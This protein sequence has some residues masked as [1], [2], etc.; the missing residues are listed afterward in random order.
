MW[1]PKNWMN[2]LYNQPGREQEASA[3]RSAALVSSCQI[4][5]RTMFPRTAPCTIGIKRGRIFY[6]SR[7]MWIADLK[8]NR[9]LHGEHVALYCMNK[10]DRCGYP[11]VTTC[12]DGTLAIPECFEGKSTT[13]TKGSRLSS[14]G[15]LFSLSYCLSSLLT[16]FQNQGRWDTI[17][18]P[19]P[20]HQKF[21]CVPPC[22]LLAPQAPQDLHDF[23]AKRLERTEIGKKNG[24]MYQWKYTW[25][26]HSK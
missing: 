16:C 20:S 9:V 17:Y 3:V 15:C 22:P 6:N 13:S 24:M 10:A 8:P 12:N 4:Q 1:G 19:K 18:G 5:L 23:F 21:K 11:V 7:K 25:T 14:F 26:C 2:W